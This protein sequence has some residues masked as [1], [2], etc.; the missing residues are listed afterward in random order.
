MLSSVPGRYF[1]HSVRKAPSVAGRFPPLHQLHSRLLDF[2][3]QEFA[4][5]SQLKFCQSSSH[6]VSLAL[7]RT[8]PHRVT[9]PAASS[10]A[11]TSKICCL[12]TS[13]LQMAQCLG[14]L[15]HLLAPPGLITPVLSS[16]G[17]PEDGVSLLPPPALT[18]CACRALPSHSLRH[19][20]FVRQRCLGGYQGAV[21]HIND[22]VHDNASCRKREGK[23]VKAEHPP[24]GKGGYSQIL[25]RWEM[26]PCPP[27]LHLASV[28]PSCPEKAKAASLREDKGS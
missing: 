1:A 15:Q 18:A 9:R 17:S 27:E 10:T 25:G 21:L 23:D 12:S 11:T 24:A 28:Q 4:S 7:V 3:C 26:N 14:P 8:W 2:C 13:V 6:K 5:G 16:W 20:P 22:K 19:H